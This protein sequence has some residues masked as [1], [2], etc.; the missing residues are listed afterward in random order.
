MICKNCGSEIPDTAKF[1]PKCGAKV[2]IEKPIEFGIQK[3]VIIC[4]KCET[5]NPSIAKFCK[6]C[7]IPLKEKITPVITKERIKRPSKIWIWITAICGLILV[8]GGIGSYLYFSEKIIKKP[9]TITFVINGRVFNPNTMLTIKNG[10]LLIS[11][12]FV[13]EALGAKVKED[14]RTHTITIR[15]GSSIFKIAEG[16]KFAYELK[17]INYIPQNP[18]A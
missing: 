13:A 11:V 15:K 7:G 9:N 10:T 6:K 8:I 2:E 17:G 1:C 14:I 4:K 16:K 5:E 18:D 12:R 3:E